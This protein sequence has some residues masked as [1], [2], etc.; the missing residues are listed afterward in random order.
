MADASPPNT[1]Y[2]GDNLDVLRQHVADASVDLVYLDPPFNSNA[3]YNVLFAEQDGTRAAAQIEAFKD[4]WRW[5]EAAAEAFHAV[6]TGDVA[7]ENPRVADAMRAF[8]TL[9]PESDMLAYLSM[10]APRLVELRR[11]LKDT[12]SL[13]LHCDPTASHYLKLVLDAVFG[14]ENFKSEVIWKRTGTHSSAKRWGPVHDT[15]LFYSRDEDRMKW[16]RQFIP[17]DPKHA[18]RHYRHIDEQ[19]RRFAHGELT[20]PGTRNGRSGAVWHGF[21]V[22]KLGRH[23]MTTVEKLDEMDKAGQ[24]HWPKGGGWPRLKK[25][26]RDGEGRAVGDVMAD[27]PPINMKAAERLGYPTQKPEALLE[28]IIQASSDEGDV[29]LDPFC[30]CGT[31][32]VAAQKLKRRWVGIDVTHLAVNL[33]KTRLKGSFNLEAKKDYRVVGEPTSL[34]GAAELAANDPFQFQAWALGLANARVASS[35]KKGADRGI[36]GKLFFSDEEKKSAKTKSA[37]FSVKAGKVGVAMVRDLVGTLDREAKNG[38]VIGVL[39]SMNEPTEPMRKEAASAGRYDSPWGTSH[40]RVQL[41]TVGDLLGGKRVDLPPSG[42][43][44]TFKNAPRSKPRPREAE[45]FDGAG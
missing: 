23:W 36:D 26:E 13:Y 14:P 44:R 34:S 25:Y 15:V 38:A 11:V 10:M 29:V 30:G 2:Y 35:A 24:I 28:R 7:M 16:N 27:I 22:T 21:D 42:D 19:G 45:L 18:A 17:L 3:D 6:T 32:V 5:D 9:V 12:G 4:T 31:A 43:L 41:L 1:L 8:A 20:A 33:I 37:L 40:P 39:I